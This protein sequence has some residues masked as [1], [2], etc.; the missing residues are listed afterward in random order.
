MGLETLLLLCDV[1]GG[2]DGFQRVLVCVLCLLIH[3]GVVLPGGSSAGSPAGPADLGKGFS[4]IG[5]GTKVLALALGS[6]PG[7]GFLC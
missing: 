4:V 5:R 7:R 3:R 6:A 1:R 2:R